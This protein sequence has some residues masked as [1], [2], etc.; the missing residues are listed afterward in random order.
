MAKKKENKSE[1]L[2]KGNTVC[3]KTCGQCG[4]MTNIDEEQRSE[5]NVMGGCFLTGL[6]VFTD[7]YSCNNFEQFENEVDH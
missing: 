3:E 5:P 7:L 4:H 2:W 1:I 6:V